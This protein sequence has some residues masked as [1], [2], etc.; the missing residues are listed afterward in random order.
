M[1]CPN[2]FYTAPLL[3]LLRFLPWMYPCRWMPDTNSPQKEVGSKHISIHSLV[4]NG[5]RSQKTLLAH[6]RWVLEAR[7][8]CSRTFLW[9]QWSC[10][11]LPCFP[12]CFLCK[13][14]ARIQNRAQQHVDPTWQLMQTGQLQALSTS[15]TDTS[16]FQDDSTFNLSLLKA[17]CTITS[18]TGR[19]V[20]DLG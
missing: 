12:A 13:R 8:L 10:Q 1:L 7:D 4:W 17:L 5:N 9:Y 2:T 20:C 19:Q 6:Y 16:I 14:S 15:L 11:L 3:Y 18:E